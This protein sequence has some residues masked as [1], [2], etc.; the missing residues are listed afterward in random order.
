[1]SFSKSMFANK[2]T[3]CCSSRSIVNPVSSIDTSDILSNQI[4][5]SLKNIEK[6]YTSNLANQ[7]YTNIP[8][9][10]EDYAHLYSKISQLRLKTAKNT[11]ISLFLNITLEG[12]RGAINAIGLT[13]TVLELNIKNIVLQNQI[14][15]FESGYNV[16]LTPIGTQN[17]SI[18]K[19]FTLAPVYSY[20]IALFGMPNSQIGFDPN[21]ISV[22]LSV[23]E[24]L[25]IDPYH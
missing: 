16:L 25:G 19:S 24:K 11:S 14:D 5:M 17:L 6:N 9:D 21:K 1:M 23:L 22:L 3:G 15:E 12:L 20:Y 18:T 4:I 10:Y 2:I 13:T 7:Q 8:N